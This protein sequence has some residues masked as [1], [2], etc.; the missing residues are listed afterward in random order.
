MSLF[1][2]AGIGFQWENIRK[3][4]FRNNSFGIICSQ[5]VY[6]IATVSLT[7]TGVLYLCFARFFLQIP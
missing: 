3:L 5:N 7:R 2:W 6:F 1:T 4:K